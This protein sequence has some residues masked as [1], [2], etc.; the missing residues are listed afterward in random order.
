MSDH[1]LGYLYDRY[2]SLTDE[3]KK[4][5][6]KEI[7]RASKTEDLTAFFSGLP[8]DEKLFSLKVFA[9]L[10]TKLRKHDEFGTQWIDDVIIAH[11]A[12]NIKDIM[13][14]MSNY[15]F[16]EKAA[17]FRVAEAKQKRDRKSDPATVRRN[18]E[19]CDLRGQ[20][21]KL[22][23]LNRLAKKY[24]C[25]VRNITKVLKD[26]PRWRQLAREN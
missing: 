25:T 8:D 7:G 4:L 12:K 3:D 22:W 23:T 5:F 14:I 2:Y 1:E 16:M 11:T 19:I 17:E 26:E 6:V 20:N 9:L 13:K 24:K 21:K 18:V 10:I 15:E